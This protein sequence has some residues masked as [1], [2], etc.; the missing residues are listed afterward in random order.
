MGSWLYYIKCFFP[1]ALILIYLGETSVTTDGTIVSR[2]CLLCFIFVGLLCLMEIIGKKRVF[3]PLPLL[4]L[5]LQIIYYVLGERYHYRMDGEKLDSFQQIKIVIQVF[6]S[7]YIFC[8]WGDKNRVTETALKYT[9]FLLFVIAIAHYMSF[10]M[11]VLY[12]LANDNADVVNNAS[13]DFVL[14][15]PYLFFIRNKVLLILLWGGLLTFII[16]S[17]KRGAILCGGLASIFFF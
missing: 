12:L 4:F 17:G 2:I 10:Q 13:Y 15:I 7:F 1:F 5:I 3:V 14:I 16:I 11:R 9:A 6:L 8:Y